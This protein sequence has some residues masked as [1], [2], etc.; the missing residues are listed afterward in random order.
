[1]TKFDVAKKAVSLTVGFGTSA[2]IGSAIK[3]NTAP[4]NTAD[5]VAMPVAAV[6]LAW[7]ISDVTK[8]F[9]D[10]KMD[11]LYDWYLKNVR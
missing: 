1:M 11:E 9:T 2:I 3:N 5:K 7:M 8:K 6:A 10:A 4:D